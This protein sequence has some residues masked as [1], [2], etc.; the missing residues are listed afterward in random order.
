[1]KKFSRFY[2]NI[3]FMLS[4]GAYCLL[5]VPASKAGLMAGI[6]LTVGCYLLGLFLP[7]TWQYMKKLPERDIGSSLL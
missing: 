5:A 7:D 4:F 2:Q 6:L 3:P 1:M